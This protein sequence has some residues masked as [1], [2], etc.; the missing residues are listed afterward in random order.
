MLTRGRPKRAAEGGVQLAGRSRHG[1]GHRPTAPNATLAQV[2][3]SEIE[4]GG[5][6]CATIPGLSKVEPTKSWIEVPVE[7]AM[8]P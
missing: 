4:T 6:L 8:A 7:T 2:G 3:I 1:A 5:N